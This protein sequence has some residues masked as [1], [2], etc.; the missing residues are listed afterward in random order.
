MLALPLL[1]ACVLSD[2]RSSGDGGATGEGDTDGARLDG[3]T[4]DSGP[5]DGGT[6]DGG[7][8]DGGSS[9]GGSTDGG[10]PDGGTTDGG[11]PDG[12]S[13]DGGSPDPGPDLRLTGPETVVETSGSTTTSSGC[14]LPWRRYAPAVGSAGPLVILAHGLERDGDQMATWARH[15]A[16]WGLDVLTPDQCWCGVLDLDQAQNA[17]DMLELAATLA[18]RR[19]WA[20]HSAGGL[21]S[22]L[23][24]A[25]DTDARVFLGL[26][27]TEWEGLA[28]A[29]VP[30]FSVPA[31]ALVGDP[32]ICNLDNNFLPLLAALPGGAR[33]LRLVDADHCDFESPTDWVCTLACGTSSN[34]RFSDAEIQQAM[35]GLTTA[36]LRQ[37]AG[38]ATEVDAWWTPGGEWYEI[39]LALGAIAEI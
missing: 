16:S 2:P 14:E 22:F 17:Q 21:G 15:Y 18:P 35:L 10:S 33:S 27:P 12:G 11:S 30:G 28:E 20:G 6:N 26:D 36:V 32:G 39:L 1:L 29:Q 5:P 4:T 13:P 24:A 9:D 31:W 3:G 19:L 8:T 25:G 7:G 38:L 37:Q 34:D 23:A